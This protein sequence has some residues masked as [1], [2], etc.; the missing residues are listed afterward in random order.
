MV[1]E[2]YEKGKD[3]DYHAEHIKGLAEHLDWHYDSKGRLEGVVD[4]AASQRTLSGT[5]SVA[6]LFYERDILL[7]TKV[8]KDVFSGIARVKSYLKSGRLFI[9]ST[10]RNLIREIKSYWWGKDDMPVKKDD[11]ALDALR[12]YIM[13]RPIT[14]IMGKAED[15]E[16]VKDKKK[17]IRRN[18]NRSK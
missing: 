2:W 7:D 14:P 6:Q 16:I 11:H 17:L 12:Y 15:S 3:V 1:G 4:S 5:K 10:C 18:N 9:F 8:N 13:S